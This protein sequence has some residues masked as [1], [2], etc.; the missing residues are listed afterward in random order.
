[1]KTATLQSVT[2][3]R[4]GVFWSLLKFEVARVCLSSARAIS[5]SIVKATTAILTNHA[6]YRLGEL[7]PLV[8]LHDDVNVFGHYSIFD[9]CE[10][11]VTL[12]T[13]TYPIL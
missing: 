2:G 1:M 4:G 11:L 10:L 5:R 8:P 3:N 9:D 7:S 12:L 6:V 13:K